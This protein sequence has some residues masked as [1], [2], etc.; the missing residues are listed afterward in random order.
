L[1]SCLKNLQ[2]LK[3]VLNIFFQILHYFVF[4][5]VQSL[6]SWQDVSHFE[7]DRSEL[8]DKTVT[9][10][11]SID[12]K[13]SK[14]NE[15]L[16]RQ[17]SRGNPMKKKDFS[18]ETVEQACQTGRRRPHGLFNVARC[19]LF[20]LNYHLKLKVIHKIWLIFVHFA[21]KLAIICLKLTQRV[22]CNSKLRPAVSFSSFT[23][24]CA[25]HTVIWVWHA[26]LKESK[27]G[28]GW[29]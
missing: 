21:I 23:T 16:Q 1:N 18:L 7:I 2:H 20:I 29:G 4:A 19:D 10:S 17:T 6:I 14:S 3:S 12:E 22:K 27:T 28:R 5:K 8:D 26:W 11:K 13:I 15:V 25:A 24:Q 9:T